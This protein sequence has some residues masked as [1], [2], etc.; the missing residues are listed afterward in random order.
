MARSCFI[1][2]MA[3]APPY[4]KVHKNLFIGSKRAL[5][6]PDADFDVYISAAEEIKPPRSIMDAFD[7]YHIPLK[8]KPWEF[9]QH[10]EELQR[11]VI[12]AHDIAVLVKHGNR[13]LI[14]CHMGMNRSG[15]MAALTLMNL[16]YTAKQAVAAIRKR[17]GCALSN[18]SFVRALSYAERMIRRS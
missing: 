12:T 4:T 18:S 16:G 9:E 15:L 11:L 7:A 3:K 6:A 13:V 5:T 8:D 10:P 2:D 14:F 17:H 1:E